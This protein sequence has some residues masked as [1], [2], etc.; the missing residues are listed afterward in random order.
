M[1]AESSHRFG[2]F[3]LGPALTTALQRNRSPD[4]KAPEIGPESLNPRDRHRF[5]IREGGRIWEFLKLNNHSLLNF[6]TKRYLVFGQNILN[7]TKTLLE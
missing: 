1:L 4:S 6:L 3:G 5:A 7:L 2:T